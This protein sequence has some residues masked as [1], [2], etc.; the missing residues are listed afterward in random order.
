MKPWFKHFYRVFFRLTL[1]LC[2]AAILGLILDQVV[3]CLGGALFVLVVWYS[4]NLIQL[5]DWLSTK[6]NLYPPSS[7][8]IWSDIFDGIYR[9]Q[10]KNRQRRKELGQVLKR[11]R[12]GAEALPDAAVVVEESGQIIWCNRLARQLF[13]LRWPDDNGVQIT[14]LLRYPEFIEHFNENVK[15]KNLADEPVLIPSPTRRDS[16]IEVRMVPYALGQILLLGRDVTQMHRVNQMRKDFIA[17]VSHELRTPLTV[18]QGYLEMMQ[19]PDMAQALPGT[20]AV[21]MMSDQTVR[22]FSLVNQLLVLS[23][24]EANEENIFDNVVDVPNLMHVIE[25]EANQLNAEKGHKIEFVIDDKIKVYGVEEELR[26][27]FTNLIKNAIRYTPKGGEIKVNWCDCDG[28]ACFSVVDNGDGIESKHL[29]RLTER[30]YRVDKAR[31]RATGGS[32]LG[33]SIVKH[34]LA[35]HKSELEIH[36]QVGQGSRFS[37]SFPNDVVVR[38][39]GD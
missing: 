35:H 26:S 13:G 14:H 9:L 21:N 36:S 37:F 34:V 39:S 1:L 3:L 18:L 7:N 17:N 16:I 15:N 12:D 2:L 32:G 31:S 22:M 24:I 8:G 38:D 27:A 19:D 30:F 33:L 23:R 11:F 5:S 29:N 6:K 4:Y 28:S 20:K 10:K 25:K